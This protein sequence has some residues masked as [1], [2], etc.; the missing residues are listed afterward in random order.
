MDTDELLKLWESLDVEHRQQ[1][2]VKVIH[3]AEAATSL[4][5]AVMVSAAGEGD[6]DRVIDGARTNAKTWTILA[7]ELSALSTGA[8]HNPATGTGGTGEDGR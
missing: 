6:I 1:L 4:V 2:A 8:A 3:V 5:A 7:D